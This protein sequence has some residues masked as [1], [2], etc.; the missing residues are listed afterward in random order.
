MV[1][2]AE[3][4]QQALQTQGIR[5]EWLWLTPQLC[6]PRGEDLHM[7]LQIKMAAVGCV[8]KCCPQH[9]DQ[10]PQPS[11]AALWKLHPLL[12]AVVLA[13]QLLNHVWH[14]ATPWIAMPQASLSFT[15]F[16]SLL[17]FMSMESVMPS[18][19]HILCRSLFLPSIFPSI[20]VFSSELALRFRWPYYWSFSFSINPSNEYSGLISF[21]IDWFDLLAVQGTLK[22]LLQ[23]HNLKAS[24]LC[25]CK[26]HKPVSGT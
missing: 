11:C 5:V 19:H 21:S 13:V 10:E 26:A 15:I 16:W 4:L 17:K 2:I 1:P 6:G 3:A 24:I 14:F 7:T 18:N 25:I 22:S 8:Q 20:R 9:C 12:A 23:H